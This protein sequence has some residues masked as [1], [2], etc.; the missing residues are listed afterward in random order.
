MPAL[1]TIRV[2]LGQHTT[3]VYSHS[4]QLS[5]AQ[6]G[7]INID[8]FHR[9]PVYVIELDS[10]LVLVLYVLHVRRFTSLISSQ[11]RILFSGVNLLGVT[12]LSSRQN[13]NV[14][15]PFCK[16]AIYYGVLT[17]R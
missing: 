14:L 1:H 2:I 5:A 13:A 3:L 9:I 4:A 12:T 17:S 11:H 10:L 7:C 16:N 8:K 15:R 6:C